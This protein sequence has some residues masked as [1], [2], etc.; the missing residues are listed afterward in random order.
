MITMCCVK[1]WRISSVLWQI[2]YDAQQWFL[3]FNERNI[4]SVW[5]YKF[6]N[7]WTCS[8]LGADVVTSVWTHINIYTTTRLNTGHR[9][10][11]LSLNHQL[12]SPRGSHCGL[13]RTCW[14]DGWRSVW[15]SCNDGWGA[16][17]FSVMFGWGGWG[18]GCSAAT[19]N[20]TTRCH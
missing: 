2:L 10:K 16:H 20:F 11:R 4:N 9:W 18:E 12:S 7:P 13:E 3:S 5:K 1:Y 8:Y 6:M 17:R 19:C 14:M 15:M